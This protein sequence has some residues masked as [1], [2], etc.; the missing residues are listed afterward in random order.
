MSIYETKR[1]NRIIE[2]F[3]KGLTYAEIAKI[4]EL[5]RERVRMI[6]KRANEIKLKGLRTEVTIDNRK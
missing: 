6:V 5:S 4:V 1:N 2:L 3:E